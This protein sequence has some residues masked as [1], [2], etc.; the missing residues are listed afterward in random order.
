MK[1]LLMIVAA[2]VVTFYTPNL[3]SADT[4]IS[5]DNATAFTEIYDPPTNV[6]YI[7]AVRYNLPQCIW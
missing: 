6:N 1:K 3:A 2:I 4:P 5:I 7:F